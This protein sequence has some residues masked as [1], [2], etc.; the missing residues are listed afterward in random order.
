MIQLISHG[1]PAKANTIGTGP[2]C[3]IWSLKDLVESRYDSVMQMI[4]RDD[5]LAE[6]VSSWIMDIR[7]EAKKIEETCSEDETKEVL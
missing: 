1:K 6:K 2:P 7:I 5:G 4:R 3:H